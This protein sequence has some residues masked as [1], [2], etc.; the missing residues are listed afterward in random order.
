MDGG[1]PRDEIERLEAHIEQ[2]AATI[3]SCRKFILAS[4]LAIALGGILLL[5]LMLGAIRFDPMVMA[6][7]I[8]ALLGG[9]V[10]L[11]SN[12]STQ[13]QAA[14]Q[15]REAEEQ[16]NALIALIDPR[17]VHDAPRDALPTLH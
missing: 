8:A 5:A 9:I 6:A 2:L 10:L 4:R 13:K 1:D 11:G 7:T 12:G 15:L 16:R 3:E 14:A 17:V